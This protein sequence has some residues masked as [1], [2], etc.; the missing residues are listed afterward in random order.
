MEGETA[1]AREAAKEREAMSEPQPESLEESHPQPMHWLA[2]VK[3]KMGRER[4]VYLVA[5]VVLSLAAVVVTAIWVGPII[6]NQNKKISDTESQLAHEAKLSDGKMYE[7]LLE[8]FHQLEAKTAARLNQ[9]EEKCSKGLTALQEEMKTVNEKLQTKAGIFEVELEIASLNATKAS[10]MAFDGLTAQVE[11][12]DKE[13]VHKTEFK[14]LVANL[15]S[16]REA[17]SEADE[18]LHGELTELALISLNYTHYHQLKQEIEVLESA[19]A[20]Q[21]DFENLV[22]DVAQLENNTIESIENTTLSLHLSITE[23]KT[24]VTSLERN[25]HSTLATK[26]S[27]HDLERLSGRVESLESSTV[28]TQTFQELQGIVQDLQASKVNKADLDQLQADVNHLKRTTATRTEVMDLESRLTGHASSSDRA[29]DEL[30]SQIDSNRGGISSNTG[31]ISAAEND[32][33]EIK[34]EPSASP[35]PG[36]QASWMTVAIS[37]SVTLVSVSTAAYYY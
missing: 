16:L 12:L 7:E 11:L 37:V 9:L 29:H 18:N 20:S 32:I 33:R 35:G 31:R 15:T 10:K 1:K 34:T 8:K 2:Q 21:V 30:T 28:D 19:T 25:V 3:K 22:S 24:N 17:S 4:N 23:L 6:G 5:A 36:L 26:A 14:I 27:R 13:K